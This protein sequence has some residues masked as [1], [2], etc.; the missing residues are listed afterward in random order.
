MLTFDEKDPRRFKNITQ[1]RHKL[2][3]GDVTLQIMRARDPATGLR[4]KELIIGYKTIYHNTYTIHVQDLSGEE[5]TRKALRRHEVKHIWEMPATGMVLN[6]NQLYVTLTSAGIYL[7]Y[8]GAK[9]AVQ[10]TN[11]EG[12][13]ITIHS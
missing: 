12:H 9:P 11:Y 7:A 5:Y 3:I 6:H 10:L 1:W 13:L 2:E 4:F 8:L